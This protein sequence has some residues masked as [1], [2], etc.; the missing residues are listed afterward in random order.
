MEGCD[1]GKNKHGHMVFKPYFRLSASCGMFENGLNVICDG[2]LVRQSE[3]Q[4]RYFV[5]P[6]AFHIDVQSSG[7][8]S[9]EGD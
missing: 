3:N 6:E 1:D 2:M 4:Y 8:D 9:A 7:L 5:I